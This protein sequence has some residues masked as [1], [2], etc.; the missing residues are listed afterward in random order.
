MKQRPGLVPHIH[1][2]SNGRKMTERERCALRA[3][4][5]THAPPP[6]RRPATATLLPEPSQERAAPLAK[7]TDG[8]PACPR[9]LTTDRIPSSKT[10]TSV[11][12]GSVQRGL[13]AIR[14]QPSRPLARRHVE[15][16]GGKP[17]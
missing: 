7:P 4:F 17:L 9:L 2:N 14:L 16:A 11:V 10:G 13:P 12:G 15:P 1:A 5:L 6:R 8:V 3:S